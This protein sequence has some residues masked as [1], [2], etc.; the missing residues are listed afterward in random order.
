MRICD[1][2][3][4]PHD[5]T[6]KSLFRSN[7][8]ILILKTQTPVYS[9]NFAITELTILKLRFICRFQRHLGMSLF[10]SSM[11]QLYFCRLKILREDSQHNNSYSLT[12]LF[13]GMSMY[14]RPNKPGFV[15][16][17]THGV[18]CMKV[19]VKWYCLLKIT[20][21][22]FSMR[23]QNQHL[24]PKKTLSMQED[25]KPR[26]KMFE[27][28]RPDL[29]SWDLGKPHQWVRSMFGLLTEF[30]TGSNI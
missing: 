7:Y 21:T 1:L 24:K 4:E 3:V 6:E 19:N 25:Y 22:V 5:W 30:D 14:F 20:T 8:G 10:P 9:E 2:W 13:R 28:I 17:K 23:Q 18:S 29:N 26:C 15:L 16:N 27:S 12:F 11:R